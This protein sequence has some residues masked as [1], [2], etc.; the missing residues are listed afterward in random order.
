MGTVTRLRRI[1]NE[2]PPTINGAF[3]AGTLAYGLDGAFYGVTSSGGLYGDGILYS[4]ATSGAF[5]KLHDFDVD[6][7]S[8]NNGGPAGGVVQGPDGRFYGTS[9]YS[10]TMD[11]YPGFVF[12]RETDGSITVL[13]HFSG[14]DG[15]WPLGD[16]MVA[17][18]GNIYGTTSAGGGAGGANCP[19]NGCG[20]I[21]RVLPSGTVETV[22]AFDFTNGSTP[23]EG[24]L[25]QGTDGYLYGTTQSG[26]NVP[27]PSGT[28][29]KISLNGTF[30]L[31]HSFL[32]SEGIGPRSSLFQA[33][34]GNFYGVAQGGVFASSE[35]KGTVFQLTPGGAVTVLHWFVGPP[36]DWP[37]ATSVPGGLV[38]GIDGH[39][40]GT[41]VDSGDYN[42]G[43]VFRL[44]LPKAQDDGLAV[45][46]DTA[47]NGIL[48]ATDP[49]G[50]RSRIQRRLERIEGN[51]HSRRCRDRRVHLY[52]KLERDRKRQFHVQGKQRHD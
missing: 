28:A 17:S 39:F 30:T 29:F 44:R 32:S 27:F 36:G 25:V 51:G 34:D 8:Q 23:A 5:T 19:Y 4:I 52:A 20:T 11:R 7:I 35:D 41:R 42:L 43:V 9:Q 45:V 21:F 3:P 26:G 10:G 6:G 13:H 38:E 1:Y 31:L 18:D 14:P 16:L 24:R 47:T 40:Y 48:V 2:N 33:G 46:E 37:W 50:A 49:A 22:H 12:R 15:Q